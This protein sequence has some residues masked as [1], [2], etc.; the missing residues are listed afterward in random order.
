MKNPPTDD[1]GYHLSALYS[2][3]GW[4]SW[5][6]C[7][8]EFLKAKDDPTQ[9]QVFVNTVLAE[10][11]EER[12]SETVE[13]SDL[14]ERRGVGYPEAGAG[15]PEAPSVPHGVGALV[16]A[17]DLQKDRLE[18][19]VVGFGAGMEAWLIAAFMCFS[20]FSRLLKEEKPQPPRIKAL[21]QPPRSST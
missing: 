13:A 20:I 18:A 14:T 16:A 4:K 2:P 1:L 8:E 21:T 15:D 19:H 5:A 11:W 10:T 12:G 7:A 6:K 3:H 9:L 17:V